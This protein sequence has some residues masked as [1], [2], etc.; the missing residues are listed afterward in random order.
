[1]EHGYE[2]LL[3]KDEAVNR[4]KDAKRPFPCS[5]FSPSDLADLLKARYESIR[6]PST[7]NI[8]AVSSA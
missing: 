2:Q 3:V 8:T 1:L 7:E 6:E 5:S 4:K